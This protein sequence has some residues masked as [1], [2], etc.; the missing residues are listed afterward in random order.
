MTTPPTEKIVSNNET[1]C[2]NQTEESVP[3]NENEE[4]KENNLEK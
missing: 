1:E 4:P 3:V 2:S